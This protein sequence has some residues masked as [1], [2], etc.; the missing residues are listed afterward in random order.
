MLD[1]VAGMSLPVIAGVP[2][3]AVMMSCA[4]HSIPDSCAFAISFYPYKDTAFFC[5]Y[6]SCVGHF[7]LVIARFL[8]KNVGYSFCLV[9]VYVYLCCRVTSEYA[10]DKIDKNTY[11][12]ETSRS[13]SLCVSHQH[14]GTG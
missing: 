7:F 3:W 1:I 8:Y 9:L 10:L 14:V 6:S 12:K 2:M 5:K 13:I 11:E 4:P